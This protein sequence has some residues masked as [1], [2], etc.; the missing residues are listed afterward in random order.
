MKDQPPQIT[1]AAFADAQQSQLADIRMLCW[2]QLQPCCQI[3]RLAALL[4]TTCCINN[5]GCTK[6]SDAGNGHKKDD[7]LMF[8]G[9]GTDLGVHG[10]DA[11]CGKGVLH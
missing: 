10:L 1:I 8:G 7:G 2:H 4:A 11:P 3:L 9:M 5:R 6:C